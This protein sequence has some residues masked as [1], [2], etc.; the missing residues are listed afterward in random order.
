MIPLLPD[1]VHDETFALL[2]DWGFWSTDA[3][4]D[5]DASPCVAVAAAVCPMRP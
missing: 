2:R 4:L 1:L 5:F 3:Q